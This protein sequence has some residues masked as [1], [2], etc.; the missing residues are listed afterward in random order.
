MLSRLGVL[1]FEKTFQEDPSAKILNCYNTM[2]LTPTGADAYIKEIFQDGSSEIS[3][4]ATCECGHISGN[5]YIGTACPICKKV[6]SSGFT[7]KLAYRYWIEIPEIMPPVPHPIV[8]KVL[9]NWLGTSVK[10][11]W[12][13]ATLLD[14]NAKRP[15]NDDGILGQG[16]EYFYNNFD[17]IIRYFLEQR[18]KMTDGKKRSRNIAEFIAENRHKCFTRH[19]PILNQSMHVIINSNNRRTSDIS[20]QYVLKAFS[21]LCTAVYSYEKLTNGSSFLNDQL[22]QV[23]MTMVEYTDRVISNKLEGKDGLFRGS[24][25][26]SR[27]HCTFR[28]VIVPNVKDHMGDELYVPWKVGVSCL[29]LEIINLLIN[30]FN[31]ELPDALE[32]HSKSLVSYNELIDKIIRTLIDECPFKGLP[33]LFGRNPG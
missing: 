16:F 21:D 14:I 1:D 19:L 28:A 10:R 15:E 3:F 8:Y 11:N 12:T 25:L 20:A 17:D 6:V 9:S 27:L 24:I 31:Y 33:V 29:K 7:S 32:L 18:S 22:Y 26:G 4:V 23:Y 13:M 30:R 5:F 2:A